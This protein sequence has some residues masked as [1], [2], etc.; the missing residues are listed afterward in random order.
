MN[1]RFSCMELAIKDVKLIQPF[2]ME[3]ERGYFLKSIEKDMYDAWKLDADVY[4]TFETYS[5][6]GVIRG[7][8]FQTKE[9]QAKIVRVIKGEIRDVVVDLRKDS[10]TYGKHLA[11]NL[12][13]YNHSILWIPKGFAHG[14]EVISEDALVSY[15]CVGKYLKDHDTGIVWN[16]TMLAI[17]W[18]TKKP[19]VSEKDANLMTFEKFHN[20]FG[21]I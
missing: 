9:P 21:G 15:S 20:N 14:F 16:D 4:E 11:V 1:T 19:I 3:D 5:K 6:K 7:L 2:Y 17:D 18:N 8:H 13:E 10:D 12:S